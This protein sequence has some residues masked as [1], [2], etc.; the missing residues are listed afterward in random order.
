MSLYVAEVTSRHLVLKLTS[1]TLV[2][3]QK[4]EIYFIK[5]ITTSL[6]VEATLLGRSYFFR[7]G[8][9]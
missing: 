5:D 6:V 2:K 8:N 7:R 1:L 4:T 9:L 3:S